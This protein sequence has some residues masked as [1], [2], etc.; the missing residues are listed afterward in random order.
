VL[1]RVRAAAL[2]R[3]DLLLATGGQ[4]GSLG[5]P[6]T[7]PGLEW[8]GEVVA[9]GPE[10]PFPLA[11]GQR[12]MATGFGGFAE[13]ACTDW[14][15]VAPVPSPLLD[16]AGAAALPN[17]L[18]TMHDALVTQGRIRPGQAVLVVGAGSGVGLMGV[19][20]AR[21]LDAGI[22]I[23]TSGSPERREGLLRHGADLAIDTADPTWPDAVR[24]A[25]GGQGVPLVID[26]VSGATVP[27]SMAAAAIGG[28]IVNVGRLGGG[29]VDFDADLHAVKP[30]RY[31]GVTFRT[32]SLDEIR[33]INAAMRR[34]LEPLLQ[35]GQMLLP[36]AGRTPFTDAAKA[37]NAMRRN[38]HFG[39]LVLEL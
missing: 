7:I 14:G 28:C 17:A 1:I 10:V 37:L 19:M 23:G 5:G 29:T 26:L 39:K 9:S 12:V 32:R 15:R 36:V 6:G 4:Y 13:Y 38:Q 8:A 30:L 34:D 3:M 2:N 16:D 25:T 11:I 27:G 18:Q 20:M 31:I 35:A 21:A 33:A 24:Q 22:V